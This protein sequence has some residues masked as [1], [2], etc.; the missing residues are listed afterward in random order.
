MQPFWSCPHILLPSP[1][2]CFNFGTSSLDSTVRCS[3]QWPVEIMKLYNL[4]EFNSVSEWV[5]CESAPVHQEISTVY[6]FFL[7]SSAQQHWT[8]TLKAMYL[9]H[10]TSTFHMITTS[11][12]QRG[13]LG[14]LSLLHQAPGFVRHCGGHTLFDPLSTIHLALRHF[15]FRLQKGFLHFATIDASQIIRIGRRKSSYVL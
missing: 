4:N 15:L 9:T 7:I 12:A 13:S 14:T 10:F 3:E 11:C 5:W 2:I 1:G 6:C 8:S